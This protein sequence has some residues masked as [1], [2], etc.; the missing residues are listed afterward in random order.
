MGHPKSVFFT[1]G[2]N[3]KK[4]NWICLFIALMGLAGHN[5]VPL[6]KEKDSLADLSRTELLELRD[7]IRG[8]STV[9]E[10]RKENEDEFPLENFGARKVKERELAVGQKQ[11]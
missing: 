2:S 11:P 6:P 10:K 4:M 8:L 3:M 7:L 5:A 9:M 1:F